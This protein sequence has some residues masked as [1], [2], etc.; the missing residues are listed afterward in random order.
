MFNLHTRTHHQQRMVNA[1]Y[2]DA[3]VSQ[4]KNLDHQYNVDVTVSV[5][6]TL[7]AILSV[8]ESLDHD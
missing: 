7:S 8:L 6:D 2:V 1:L 3:H 4:H 5:Y